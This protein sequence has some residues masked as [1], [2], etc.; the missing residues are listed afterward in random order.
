MQAFCSWTVNDDREW[1]EDQKRFRGS[2]GSTVWE[3]RCIKQESHRKVQ[4][5]KKAYNKENFS[6][7]TPPVAIQENLSKVGPSEKNFLR[8]G[9]I[10]LK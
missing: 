9:K 8:P 1:T 10:F 6:S 4:M 2:E 3:K 5:Y 7:W